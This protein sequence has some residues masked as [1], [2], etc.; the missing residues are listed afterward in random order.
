MTTHRTD[1]SS[2]GVLNNLI[3]V[4]VG[5]ALVAPTAAAVGPAGAD[6]TVQTYEVRPTEDSD[7]LTFAVSVPLD[8]SA[9]PGSDASTC[10]GTGTDTCTGSTWTTHC[11][12]VEFEQTVF[13]GTLAQTTNK[14]TVLSGVSPG[15]VLEVHCDWFLVFGS[16]QLHQH[17]QIFIG[18]D[19]SHSG[20]AVY[21]ACVLCDWEVTVRNT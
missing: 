5:L 19:V 9:G 3:L 1:P 8:G 12:A 16:C 20:Q 17:G 10:G 13:I 7:V 14:L 21:D 6:D 2:N 11:C 18:D 15:S 4:A